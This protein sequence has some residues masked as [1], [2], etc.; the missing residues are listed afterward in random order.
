MVAQF[1][2][3]LTLFNIMCVLASEKLWCTENET[4]S[5]EELLV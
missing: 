4:T 5:V 3:F 1:C 2:E